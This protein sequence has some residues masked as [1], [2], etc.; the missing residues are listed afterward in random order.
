MFMGDN[1]CLESVVVSV[2]SE[3]ALQV[4]LCRLFDLMVL[5]SWI[6]VC[7]VPNHHPTANRIDIGN[8]DF[9]CIDLRPLSTCFNLSLWRG[10]T[11]V[12]VLNPL[13]GIRDHKVART[14]SSR[15]RLVVLD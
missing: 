5:K 12:Q 15:G 7:C 4:L 9:I 3:K 2:I 8:T 14:N 11:G 13:L 6:H 1:H 10:C